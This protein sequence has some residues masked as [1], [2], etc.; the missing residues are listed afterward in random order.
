MWRRGWD[1][2]G[3]YARPGSPG[4][5][6]GK[7][8]ADSEEPF[9]SVQQLTERLKSAWTKL[10]RYAGAYCVEHAESGGKRVTL[11]GEHFGMHWKK[12]GVLGFVLLTGQGCKRTFETPCMFY[13][14]LLR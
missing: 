1:K 11:P 12:D 7:Y 6:A 13:E 8:P 3:E 4:N 14:V 5:P 2:A 9:T 10:V